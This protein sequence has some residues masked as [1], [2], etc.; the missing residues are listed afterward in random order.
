MKDVNSKR[1]QLAVI[2][3]GIFGL[4]CVFGSTTLN[5]IMI[6]ASLPMLAHIF[7]NRILI[8]LMIGLGEGL[9][10]A[11][12]QMENSLLR[13]ALIGAIVSIGPALILG[14]GALLF[15]I[16]GAIYGAITDYAATKYGK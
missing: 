13:G 14:Q 15:M 3:S 11:D 1:M 12:S 9:D 5:L 4:F 6:S 2:I 10:L 16:A 7:F 8:G